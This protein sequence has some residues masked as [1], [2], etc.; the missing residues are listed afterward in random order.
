ML[1]ILFLK[2]LHQNLFKEYIFESHLILTYTYAHI[3][4]LGT[5]LFA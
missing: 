3:V 5:A 4:V 1:L 2:I